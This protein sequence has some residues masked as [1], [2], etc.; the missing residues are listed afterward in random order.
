MHRRDPKRYFLS[1][2]LLVCLLTTPLFAEKRHLIEEDHFVK[3]SE[4][5]KPS[6]VN[7]VLTR[8]GEFQKGR[9]R[10]LLDKFLGTKRIE[11]T[12]DFFSYILFQEFPQRYFVEKMVGSGMVIRPDGLILTNEHVVA[13]KGDLQVILSDGR[14]FPAKV[15]G[16]DYVT[17]LAVIK[18]EAED[19]APLRLG[20]SETLRVG[21]WVLAIG[22]S[23]GLEYTVSAGIVSAKGRYLMREGI[24]PYFNMIQTDAPINLGNSGG[25]LVNMKGEVVGVNT[26]IIP[27]SQSIGFAIPIHEARKV[28]P[29]LIQKGNVTR[30]WLGLIL[31]PEVSTPPKILVYQT[32]QGG[33]AEKAGLRSGDQILAING[34]EL[35]R[36]SDIQDLINQ[37]EEG[38]KVVLL[39]KRKEETLSIDVLIEPMPLP[40]LKSRRIYPAGLEGFILRL[41]EKTRWLLISGTTL[42]LV[43]LI[44]VK[45]DID[46]KSGRTM[47]R[48]EDR[49]TNERRKEETPLQEIRVISERRKED[50]RRSDRREKK[51]RFTFS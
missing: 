12:E 51:R 17:D 18:I 43:L 48:G 45:R 44:A 24:R 8:Q 22:N 7:I 9:A 49:R 16:T 35:K 14:T 4:K 15:I 13:L 38:S 19:L 39:V 50:R 3:I 33:P 5:I 34:T 47:P 29:E 37:L 2:F 21:E 28:I 10:L 23:L 41:P 32:V 27:E 25:P 42:F 46:R 20:D 40:V 30:N 11:N 1:S 26:S 31:H 6:V 36:R